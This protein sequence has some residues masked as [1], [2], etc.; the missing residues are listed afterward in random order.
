[1]DERYDDLEDWL[2]GRVDPLYPPPGT[3]DLV[4]CQMMER[5]GADAAVRSWPAARFRLPAIIVSAGQALRL[6]M[7]PGRHR[8]YSPAECGP[9]RPLSC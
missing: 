4:T 5:R 6:V 8:R 3:S 9:G 1:M 2:S 7:R